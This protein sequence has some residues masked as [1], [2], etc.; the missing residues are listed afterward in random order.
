[1][2]ITNEEARSLRR[3]LAH[4]F[5]IGALVQMGLHDLSLKLALE[6]GCKDLGVNPEY[7]LMVALEVQRPVP[8]VLHI[9]RRI[10]RAVTPAD[11]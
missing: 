5:T 9:E 10:G 3:L 11:T 2:H 4:H 6:P 1:M 8:I 7:D